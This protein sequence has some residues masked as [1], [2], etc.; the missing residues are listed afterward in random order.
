MKIVKLAAI[1]IGSNAIRLLISNVIQKEKE[2]LFKKDALYRLP[3]RLGADTFRNGLISESSIKKLEHTLLGFHHMME[4]SEVEHYYGCATSAM[5]E[6][7]NGKEVIEHLKEKTGIHIELINGK[8][9]AEIIYSTQISD[10]IDPTKNYMYVDVGGGSTEITIFNNHQ[11]IAS[12]S[13]KIG[14]VRIL[15]DKVESND[16]KQMG[17]WLKTQSQAIQDMSL[18]G[19]GGNITRLFKMSLKEKHEPLH[20]NEILQHYKNISRFSYNDRIELLDLKPDRADV[21]LPASEVF[22]FIMENAGAENVYV[23]KIGLAD[24]ITKLIFK[25]ISEKTATTAG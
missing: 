3:V 22:M 24:G 15:L 10:S 9:E 12:N 25:K 16:W 5:R 17:E 2:T 7:N 23:P 14:T 1:D 21:I 11:V 4:A 18:I 6:A 8:R 20:Y 19:S 13:F